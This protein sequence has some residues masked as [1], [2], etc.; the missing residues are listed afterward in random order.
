MVILDHHNLLDFT[1]SARGILYT[2]HCNHVICLLRIPR[3]ILVAKT[4]FGNL[5]ESIFE[6][7][8]CRGKLSCSECCRTLIGRLDV[9]AKEVFNLKYLHF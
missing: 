6:E 3:A 9:D 1:Q 2:V 7:I 5:G 4:M 8:A